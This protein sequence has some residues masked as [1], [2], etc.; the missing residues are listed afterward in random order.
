[1]A[2]SCSAPAKK[3]FTC[4]VELERE[5]CIQEGVILEPV[6]LEPWYIHTAKANYGFRERFVCWALLV[7][8]IVMIVTVILYMVLR[9]CGTIA[10]AALQFAH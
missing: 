7:F 9:S 8:S 2:L 6:I 3:V 10:N 4:V 5:A 1:M